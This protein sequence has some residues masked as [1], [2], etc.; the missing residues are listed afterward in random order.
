MSNV[1]GQP[2]KQSKKQRQRA[3]KKAAKVDADAKVD[4]NAC[5]EQ[6]QV[7]GDPHAYGD[8]MQG[9]EVKVKTKYEEDDEL[10]SHWAHEPGRHCFCVNKGFSDSHECFQ[11]FIAE[12]VVSQNA[13]DKQM[14]IL[15]DRLVDHSVAYI[16]A[17]GKIT[18][19]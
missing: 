11:R 6:M 14:I 10:N 1:V 8:Q 9:E 3:K 18:S 5:V 16:N 12:Q 15:F 17:R 2:T 13:A 4:A 7:E 19:Q